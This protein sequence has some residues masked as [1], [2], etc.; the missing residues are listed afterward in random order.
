MQT[1]TATIAAI[2]LATNSIATRANESCSG[3]YAAERVEQEIVRWIGWDARY[4]GEIQQCQSRDRVKLHDEAGR[5]SHTFESAMHLL[6]FS[7]PPNDFVVELTQE[8]LEEAAEHGST[9][10][11]EWLCRF[12]ISFLY[13][14][15][16]PEETWGPTR[17][18]GARFDG[19]RYCQTAA[20]GNAH[21]QGHYAR[22]MSLASRSGRATRQDSEQLLKE[23]AEAGRDHARRYLAY[24]IAQD[25]T[26]MEQAVQTLWQAA[27]EGDQQAGA[28]LSGIYLGAPH[29]EGLQAPWD[30]SAAIEAGQW[31]AQK[32]HPIAQMN[33]AIAGVRQ[34][35]H[36]EW[37]DGRRPWHRAEPT[38]LAG[39]NERCILIANEVSQMYVPA[40]RLENPPERAPSNETRSMLSAAL[41]YA[42]IAA[43][44]NN[45]PGGPWRCS[46]RKR[47]R[48]EAARLAGEIE[49]WLSP[50]EITQTEQMEEQITAWTKP[51]SAD[52]TE[53]M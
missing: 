34:A 41:A 21:F 23:A 45:Q 30:T 35:F 16:T 40:I 4:M 12:G 9:T 38:N 17:T 29:P 3:H 39:D 52:V 1:L 6:V 28:D 31:A 26:R 51:A 18:E 46:I 13:A 25:Q 37:H 19:L 43:D 15:E 27:S 48:I 50:A 10:A 24:H 14:P 33:M 49:P 22:A 8:R 20:A 2:V 32:G 11:T 53:W 42:R 47:I 5:E 36:P 44:E 7:A